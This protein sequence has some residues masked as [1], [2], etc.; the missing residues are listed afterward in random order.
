[1]K[2]IEQRAYDWATKTQSINWLCLTAANG[3]MQGAMDERAIVNKEL[4]RKLKEQKERLIE[5]ACDYIRSIYGDG[6]DCG[7]VQDMY[8]YGIIEAMEE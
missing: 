2:T 3:Y 7:F 1:M 8:T 5:K 6:Y 4:Q